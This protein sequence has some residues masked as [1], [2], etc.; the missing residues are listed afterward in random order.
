M[1][2]NSVREDETKNNTHANNTTALL[3]DQAMPKLQTLDLSDGQLTAVDAGEGCVVVG[4]G[5]GG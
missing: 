3:R 5:G 4:G 2:M 1:Q